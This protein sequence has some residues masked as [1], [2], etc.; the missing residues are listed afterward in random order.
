MALGHHHPSPD[1]KRKRSFIPHDLEIQTWDSVSRYFKDLSH[2]ELD[3]ESELIKWLIDRSELS[4]VLEENLAWRYIRMNCDTSDASLSKA[5]EQFVTDIQPRILLASNELDKKFY[6]CEAKNNLHP[7]TYG[8]LL[9]TLNNRMELFREENVPLISELQVEEQEYGKI[10]S[11]MTVLHEGEKLTLQQASNFLKEPDRRIRESFFRKINDRRLEDAEVLQELLSSLL[12]KRRRVG[13]NAGFSNYYE[14]KWKELGRF[15]Y[16]V[17]DIMRFHE[18][19]ASEVRPLVDQ[20]HH[21]RKKLLRIE[22]IRPWDLDVDP[23]LKAPLKPFKDV[24]ELVNKTIKSF[25]AIRPRFG[26]YLTEMKKGGFLDLDSRVGKAPGGFNY[27]LYES[28]IPFIYM[29][30]TGNLRD[31][32]TMFHEGGHA[33]HSFLSAHHKFIEFKELPSEVAELAS[34][35]MELIS[36]DQWSQFFSSE[37]D[38]KRARRSQ[39]QGVLQVLPWI[40][41]VDAFQYWLYTHNAHGFED[42]NKAWLQVMDRFGSKE[43]DWT[44]LD[45]YLNHLWQKQLHIYEVPLYYIEYGIAQLGAIALWKNYRES[46][47]KALD[48]FETALS[49]GYSKTIPEI[50]RTAGIEFK[51]SSGYV[52]ELMEFV[53]AELQNME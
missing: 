8:I 38:L 22:T 5:F 33:I 25:K 17:E 14:Y 26:R 51:F 20:I 48:S 44:G 21:Q 3:R 12:E 4:A 36:M 46:P 11:R 49:L 13:R 53:Q 24:D 2:R 40:A 41:S 52:K 28:N 7:E 37:D 19:I 16:D 32:E 47:G 31:L 6:S 23:E 29:N 15:D 42:R 9:R 27:P 50:Y 35:S 34:M 18:A 30:A 45:K 39:L 43:V 1:I 10:S